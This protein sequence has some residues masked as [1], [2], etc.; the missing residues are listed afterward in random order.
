MSTVAFEQDDGSVLNFEVGPKQ[1]A[2]RA[3]VYSAIN[4]E[5]HYQD[6]L[7]PEG[8]AALSV[9]DFILMV[10]EYAARARKEWA[11]Q[12]Y[13][14]TKALDHMRKIGAIA[15]RCMETHGAVVR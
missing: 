7:W 12:L 4:G 9:G 1:A 8:R 14:E 15:V 13:P 11:G 6:S 3:E 2:T 5:R 10:E